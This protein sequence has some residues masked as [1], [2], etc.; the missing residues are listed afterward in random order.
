MNGFVSELLLLLILTSELMGC[1]ISKK[2]S[3]KRNHHHH[4]H[5]TTR[6]ES[7]EKRSSRINSSRIDDSS[8]TKEEQDRSNCRGAKVR[9]IESEKFSSGRFSEK[10]AEI[11]Q[12]GD[13]DDEDEEDPPPP[14]PPLPEELKREPSIVTPHPK[15][16][17]EVKQVAAGWPAWLVSVAGEA[18]VDWSP[19]RASTFE[20]L[21]KV[22]FFF[23]HPFYTIP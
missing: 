9:L 3:P 19:R 21:E 20:K 2:K 10:H 6:K 5:P 14:P 15:E 13:T 16:E 18:L 17:A 22:S 23:Y 1:I 8:Q 4:H 11:S 12:I 7:S